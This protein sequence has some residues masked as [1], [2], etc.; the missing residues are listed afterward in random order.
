MVS[1]MYSDIPL[2]TYKRETSNKNWVH[3]NQITHNT[4]EPHIFYDFNI[5]KIWP[6][7]KENIFEYDLTYKGHFIT[8]IWHNEQ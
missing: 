8:P 5:L 1:E 2:H 4:F 6:I 7:P 3:I